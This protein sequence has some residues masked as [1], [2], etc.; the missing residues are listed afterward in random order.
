MRIQTLVCAVAACVAAALPFPAQAYCRGCVIE[1]PKTTSNTELL[2]LTARAEEPPVMMVQPS[3][4]FEKQ[5]RGTKWRR[6][7]I[8]E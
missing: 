5:K 8:C 2:A 4:H 3:C 1:Q 7:E 6:V